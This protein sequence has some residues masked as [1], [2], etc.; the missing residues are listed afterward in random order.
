[1]RI[2]IGGLAALVLSVAL[3]QDSRR[4]AGAAQATGPSSQVAVIPGFNPPR[5][6]GYYGVPALPVSDQQLSGYHFTQVPRDQVTGTLLKQ[7]DTVLLYGIRWSDLSATAQQAIDTF[8]HTKKVLI[9]DSDGTGPQSY[10]SFVRPFSTDAS[11]ENGKS[12]GSVVSFP[13]GDNFLASSN[14]KSPY[15]LDPNQLVTD[16]NMIND[17]SAMKLGTKGW[18]PALAGANKD[19]P[20]GGWPIAW[21]Y[22]VIGDHTGLVVYSGLDADAFEDNLS[23]NYAVKELALDLAAKFSSTPAACAPG[24]RLPSST[25]GKP[26]AACSFGKPVP[27]G[28]VHGRVR[29]VLKTSNAAAIT[30]KVVTG[31]GKVVA[32][33]R[34]RTRGVLL[35]V[36]PTKRLR[37]NHASRLKVIVLVHG[38]QACVRSFRLKVD[39]VRP[40][41][42]MLSTTGNVLRLRLSEKAFVA[43]SG[44]GVRQKR[45]VLIAGNR[46][47]DLKLPA[48]VR[49]ARLTVRD[50]AGN[51]LV[52]RLSW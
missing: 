32:V 33:G 44:R 47:A 14:P 5:Y 2:V 46:T 3:L 23:P 43:F 39:N 16:R 30:G 35:L 1:M 40:R 45:P 52:R 51:L 24:C 7:Y 37:S 19:I 42:L 20:Q 10:G 25:G 13:G 17:M 50:R 4:S 49:A 8:A 22:G 27:K 15:Y 18:V 26:F 28:W 12:N 6:P 11:G 9:W 48:S 41:L 21:T 36:V 34:E 29:L 31:S 38:Q